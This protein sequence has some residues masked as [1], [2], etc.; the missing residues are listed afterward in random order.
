MWTFHFV[1]AV[2]FI[3]HLPSDYTRYLPT[4]DSNQ[5][6][7]PTAWFDVSDREDDAEL[8][9]PPRKAESNVSKVSRARSKAVPLLHE[10]ALESTALAPAPS[11]RNQL[12]EM[13]FSKVD[14]ELGMRLFGHDSSTAT[15]FLELLRQLV[16]MGFE[17][18]RVV[19]AL[20]KGGGQ[21]EALQILLGADEEATVQRIAAQRRQEMGDQLVQQRQALQVKLNSFMS[22]ADASSADTRAY[23]ETLEQFK[24]VKRAIANLEAVDPSTT[25]GS[26]NISQQPPP[27]PPL[28]PPSSE[29]SPTPQ[30]GKSHPSDG[31]AKLL[32]FQAPCPHCSKIV[33]FKAQPSN[34]PQSVRLKLQ[35]S[36]CSQFFLIL[37]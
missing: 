31:S 23:K 17:R 18:D 19:E 20:R 3:A 7:T 9:S 24:E 11:P 16:E 13:G 12:L 27:I 1:A 26:R 2:D 4:R 14:A 37:V 6:V 34:P 28:P 29:S 22:S 8:I 30:Q 32:V 33:R 25:P 21:E 15:D 5:P 35:C 36:H 10:A